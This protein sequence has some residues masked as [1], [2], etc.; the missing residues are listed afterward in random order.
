MPLADERDRRTQVLWG[1]RDFLRRFGREPE[2]MWLSETAVDLPTLSLLAD[3]GIRF[4]IL[5]PSQAARVRDPEGG[6]W[7]DV[8]GNRVDPRVPYLCRLP[9]GG[10]IALFFYDGPVS[11]EIGFGTILASGEEFAA[12]LTG[13]FD[14]RSSPQLAHVATDGETYGHHRPFA[15]M[16]L[17]YCLH[18]VRENDL[19]RLTVYGEYLEEHPPELEV[20]IHENSSWS[21][22]HGVERWRADCGCNSGTHPGWTQGWRAPLREALDWLRDRCV[23]LYEERAGELLRDPWQARDAYIDVVL[24][25]SPDSIGRF[26][27]QWGNGPFEGQR[28]SDALKLLELQRHAMLMY[29]SCG[30]FFDE[31]SGIEST[32]VLFYAA[33]MVQLARESLGVDLEQEFVER[34]RKAPSNIPRYKDGAGVYEALVRPAEVDL[35]RVGVHYA[36]SSLVEDYAEEATIFCYTLHGERCERLTA[37]KMSLCTGRVQLSSA[38]TLE[39]GEVSFAVLHLGGHII[40]GGVRYFSGEERFEELQG[41]FREAFQRADIAEVIRLMDE[42]FG[43]HN[44][45]VWHLFRD[46]RRAFFSRILGTTLEEIR[47]QYRKIYQ[48]N[49]A[50]M[51]AMSESGVPVPA[52]L[53]TPLEFTLNQDLGEILESEAPAADRFR[54]ILAEMDRWGVHIDAAAHGLA[55]SRLAHRLLDELSEH[56]RAD[57]ILDRAVETLELLRSLQA[58]L[59]LWEA[60]NGYFRLAQRLY[61]EVVHQGEAGDAEAVEW[62]EGFRRLGELL[63]VTV[64]P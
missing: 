6:D 32:Q 46:E 60:Q 22:V 37:G 43:T 14:D 55:A 36:V 44:Y 38:I 51:Q 2:G 17:A 8:S 20:E 26:F 1:L 13:L 47:L 12:R 41:T 45:S 40:N 53:R 10:S 7:Q 18:S 62:A 3:N 30:W 42:H 58:P 48:D 16:A 35:L 52:V 29:T 25:R 61:G 39:Q 33:R 49:Y 54:E 4:T 63:G 27:E 28:R 64:T 23:P 9:G 59:N 57:G 56:P 24:D 19:A 50:I 11:Q 34:L 31:I 21:C 5:A 15:D